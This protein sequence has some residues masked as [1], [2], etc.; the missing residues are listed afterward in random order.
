ML[1]Y[2]EFNVQSSFG[3]AQPGDNFTGI[4]EIRFYGIPTPEP[5]T[6]V[7][8]GLGGI[9]LFAAARRRRKS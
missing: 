3:G 7:L 6:L 8:A 1:H 4:S 2:V 9:G 5:S